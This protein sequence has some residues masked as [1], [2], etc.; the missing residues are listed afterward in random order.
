MREATPGR[1]HEPHF[2]TSFFCSMS[3]SSSRTSALFRAAQT[4]AFAGAV[5]V[6]AASCGSSQNDPAPG[7]QGGTGVVLTRDVGATSNA[8]AEADASADVPIDIVVAADALSPDATGAAGGGGLMSMNGGAGGAA[9]AAGVDGGGGGG[10]A[11]GG[12]PDS[13]CTACEKTKCS[14]PKGV[15]ANPIQAL[16]QIGTNSVCFQGAGWPMSS[17]SPTQLGCG[18]EPGETGAVSL[19]GAQQGVNKSVLCQTFLDCIHKTS[20]QGENYDWGDCYCGAGVGASGIGMCG[21]PQYVPTGACKDS[22]LAGLES[23]SFAASVHDIFDPC[24]AT[25]AAIEIVNDCDSNCCSQECLGMS[26]AFADPTYCN[27]PGSTAGT[28]GSSGA[29]GSGSAG[30]RG[31][32]GGPGTAGG[33]GSAGA[34]GTAGAGGAGGAGNAGAGGTAGGAG[35][36]AGGT[37]GLSGTAGS[38]TAGAG[39]SIS[40]A[41][42]NATFDSS[43]A[44]WNGEPN[45]QVTRSSNDA[46]GGAQSGS[47]DVALT[48]ADPTVISKS[49][50]W[51][52]VAVTASANYGVSAKVLIPGTTSSEGGLDLWYYASADCSGG[53]TSTYSLPLSAAS[54]WTKISATATTPAAV[55]SV[56]V[57]LVIVKPYT[58]TSAEALFDDV[59]VARQ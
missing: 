48:G 10:A 19:G 53:V 25:G 43:T 39:G 28:A 49:A 31:S 41:L 54:S 23:D 2:M 52:C 5:A 51:Q 34:P 35:G 20:C 14:N 15:P 30:S 29:A 44:H 46:D 4:L 58:Q 56:A 38:S 16:T 40:T 1:V 18:E 59:V 47:L 3:P 8:D 50:V 21:S 57:R 55:Q 45:V 24:Y 37:A 11:N 33:G 12:P 6:M 42:Q 36:S 7:T 17:L 13:P 22:F 32:A 9:G 27:A 26:N